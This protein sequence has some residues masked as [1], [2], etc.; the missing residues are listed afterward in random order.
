MIELR[1]TRIELPAGPFLSAPDSVFRKVMETTALLAETAAKKLQSGPVLKT[2]S[3]FLSSRTTA[4]VEQTPDGYAIR[5]GNP[6]RYSRIL[7]LGGRTAPHTIVPKKPG[8]VLAFERGGETIFAR[9][10]DHPGS[11]FPPRPTL[12]PALEEAAAALPAR[13]EAAVRQVSGR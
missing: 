6:Q 11:V 13:M 2:Q 5:L 12:R 4:V 8:G 3:G 10:V 9:R 7:E 1:P